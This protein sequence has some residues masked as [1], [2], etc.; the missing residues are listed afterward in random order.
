MCN[1]LGSIGAD[2][3][4]HV[5]VPTSFAHATRCEDLQLP[6]VSPPLVDDLPILVLVLPDCEDIREVLW[7]Y[8]L[9]PC[10]SPT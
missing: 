6:A 8:V 5:V 3:I 4:M 7:V 2:A 9:Q 10:Q 1:P